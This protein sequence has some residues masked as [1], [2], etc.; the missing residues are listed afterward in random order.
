MSVFSCE[1]FLS[2]DV[3][4]IPCK[5]QCQLWSDVRLVGCN[6]QQWYPCSWHVTKQCAVQHSYY[7]VTKK[8]NF[9]TPLKKKYIYIRSQKFTTPQIHKNIMRRSQKHTTPQIQKT[10]WQGHKNILFHRYKKH[11]DK[12][13]KT[14]YSADTKNTMKRS[15]KHTTPQIHKHYEKVTKTYYSTD[16]KTL[17]ESHKNIPSPLNKWKKSH[18]KVTET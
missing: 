18:E 3:T 15:Q 16:R 1:N 7:Q 14:Y 17:W 5:S 12:V 10:L 11:Y 9:T 4:A 2:S 6:H 8:S 13:T